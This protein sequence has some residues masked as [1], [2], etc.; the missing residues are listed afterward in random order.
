MQDILPC[1]LHILMVSHRALS[2]VE[3]VVEFRLDSLDPLRQQAP[4]VGRGDSFSRDA[5][6]AAVSGLE[7][8]AW[9]AA[10][11]FAD[12]AIDSLGAQQVDELRDPPQLSQAA[13]LR[14]QGKGDVARGWRR[15]GT[16]PGAGRAS[17]S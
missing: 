16:V 2:L 4:L 8:A 14:P 6:R 12:A 11:T 1:K 17:R 7:R 15:R 3:Q 13:G 10:C 9:W 5:C